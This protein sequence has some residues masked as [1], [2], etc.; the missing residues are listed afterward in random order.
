MLRQA[1][2]FMLLLIV[3]TGFSQQLQYRQGELIIKLNHEITDI[4]SI[5]RSYQTFQGRS[6]RIASKKCLSEAMNI[7]LLQFDFT[8]VH[9]RR[10][11]QLLR[12][13]SNIQIAQFNHII[14]YRKVPNDPDF[15]LQWQYINN[16]S[17]GGV[18]DIDLDADLAWEITTG[19]VTPNGD[20]IVVAALDDGLD[21]LHEDIIE[22]LWINQQEIPN[23]GI[24]DDNNGFIDDINGWN[25]IDESGTI[26]GGSHGTPVIGI[27]GAK[28]NNGIGVTGVS[29]D[30]KV[31]MIQTNFQADEASILAG[32]G[33]PLEMRKLYNDSNGER[34]AFVVATNASWGIDEGMP[35]DAPIWC[36]M[37]DSLGAVGIL[38]C[39]ATAN[40]NINVDIQGDLPTTCPSDFLIGVTNVNRSGEKEFFAGFGKENIDI[41]AFGENAF[42]LARGN[43]YDAFGGTSGATPHVTGAIGLLYSAPC[44]NFSNLAKNNPP[45]AALLA[46]EYILNGAKPNPN[47]DTLVATGGHLNLNNSLVL[48]MQD[49]GP[50]PSPLGVSFMEITDTSTT[51]SWLNSEEAITTSIRYRSI[52]LEV[53]TEANNVTAPF[54]LTDL[55]ACTEY[56]FQIK[57]DCQEETSGYSPSFIFKTDGCC[58]PPSDIVVMQ[59]E[60]NSISIEWEDLLAAQSYEISFSEVG[61]VNSQSFT[62]EN[63][64]IEFTNLN[65]CTPYQIQVRTVCATMTT[66]FSSLVIV[67]TKGC[68]SC[69]DAEYCQSEGDGQFEWISKVEL[70]TINNESGSD[71]GYGDYTSLSTDLNTLETYQLTVNIGYESFPFIENIQVWIDFNQDGVF[72]EVSENVVDLDEDIADVLV[73]EFMVPIDAVEGL[74]RMRVAMKWREGP[75]PSKP[76][77]CSIYDFGEVEDYCVNIITTERPCLIPNNIRL[78]DDPV[79]NVVFL[80]WDE[81]IGALNYELRYRIV[82]SPEWISTTIND[83]ATVFLDNLTR[84]ASYELQVQ[85]L[86]DSMVTSDFSDIFSFNTP[87]DCLP[88]E[89][90]SVIDS[91]TNSISITWE[92]NEEADRY[93]VVFKKAADLNQGRI[94]VNSNTLTL[95]SLDNCTEYQINIRPLCLDTNGDLSNTFITNTRCNVG[96]QAPI[97]EFERL[98]ISPNPFR[99]LLKIELELSKKMPTSFTF[100]SLDGKI[101]RTYNTSDLDNISFQWQLGEYIDGIYLLKIETPEGSLLKKVIKL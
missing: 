89:A 40:E 17:A 34:G 86:C 68:G 56:E 88:P 22:N 8:K 42:T 60:L 71:N 47:L 31:M 2:L 14:K 67:S 79:D 99:N 28:G 58:E 81:A 80:A 70:N 12:K 51:I 95:S 4:S 98:A 21:I 85:S 3:S 46:K 6:S 7:W 61:G 23:N 92:D 15:L 57:S 27:M 39:G 45:A 10:F 11:L 76:A 101:L 43:S 53:W 69:T 16:G 65:N 48:L 54:F 100:F 74:T 93:E 13:D 55:N 49:C 1:I 94:V 19:G 52:G 72:D 41:G 38:N 84:C 18:A 29:W 62:T 83:P 97:L 78:L 59:V 30:V 64:F 24:D 44:N 91:S 33:Y 87:C 32:Y 25:I 20:T 90:I 26:V 96:L 35:E 63:N 75:D 37:Y 9:E 50:C 77:S 82:D 36:A 66:D 5:L 73:T